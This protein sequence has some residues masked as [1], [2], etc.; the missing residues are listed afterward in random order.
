[1]V[2]AISRRAESFAYIC[3]LLGLQFPRG[4]AR[5]RLLL[6][7]RCG[8]LPIGQR[9]TSLAGATP[10][11]PGGLDRTGVVTV[12]KIRAPCIGPDV[13]GFNSIDDYQKRSRSEEHTTDSHD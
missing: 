10:A 5:S 3:R 7:A 2:I 4:D 11:A 13:L 9:M 12:E 6:P 1:M 8:L